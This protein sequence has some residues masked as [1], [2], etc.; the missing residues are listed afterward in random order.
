[1]LLDFLNVNVWNHEAL[2][3]VLIENEIPFRGG[4]LTKYRPKGI[5]DL[6]QVVL[7]LDEPRG[8]DK[9]HNIAIDGS[10]ECQLFYKYLSVLQ[11]DWI[12]EVKYTISKGADRVE[13]G[14]AWKDPSYVFYNLM[15]ADPWK[16]EIVL[17]AND[18]CSFEHY[19]TLSYV[20]P[21]IQGTG[22]RYKRLRQCRKADCSK[23]FI[24][25]RPKQEFC[26]DKCRLNYHN[27]IYAETG[28]AAAY[29]KKARDEGRY[30]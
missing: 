11:N 10:E 4:I 22:D 15:D 24:Y 17:T 7:W 3:N 30:Q 21:F 23:W 12:A 8:R 20:R 18:D 13:L 25:N 6:Q 29:M 2:R 9:D 16:V 26:C 14:R 19:L 1:M 28:K 27:A 5:P